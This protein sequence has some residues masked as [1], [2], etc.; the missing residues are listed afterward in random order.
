MEEQRRRQ[1]CGKGRAKSPDA[2]QA[3]AEERHR[4]ADEVF[5]AAMDAAMEASMREAEMAKR[6]QGS[7]SRGVCAL[8]I[9][10]KLQYFVAPVTRAS[11]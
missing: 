1:A 9:M 5:F 3:T 6:R 4:Q 2:A 11:V 7:S 10:I 8:L